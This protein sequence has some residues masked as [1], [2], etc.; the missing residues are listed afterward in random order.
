MLTDI[1]SKGK[2]IHPSLYLYKLLIQIE[3]SF[4]KNV[5][6][7]DCYNRVIAEILDNNIDKFPCNT[8]ANSMT[9]YLIFY[10]ISMRM[11]QYTKVLN[12]NC[13]K[14]NKI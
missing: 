6:F 14:E 4:S 13:S 3:Q 11:K 9:S 10:F 12:N 5:D 2:L 1:K 7:P 8:H